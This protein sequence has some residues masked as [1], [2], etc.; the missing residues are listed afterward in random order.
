[1]KMIKGFL[2]GSA[3]A[4]VAVNA[5]HA[6]DLPLKAP[7]PAAVDSWTGFYFGGNIGYGWGL[8]AD[9]R[10]SPTL[11]LSHRFCIQQC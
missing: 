5:G 6:A 10:L 9:Q 11:K 3:A 8:Y 1:M 2:L 4:F 7:P